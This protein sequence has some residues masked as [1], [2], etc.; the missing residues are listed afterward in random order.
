MEGVK[1]SLQ[2][3]FVLSRLLDAMSVEMI[4][5]KRFL[6]PGTGL[7]CFSCLVSSSQVLFRVDG[8]ILFSILED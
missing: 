5:E 7:R 8:V 4:N 3:C 2:G 6:L 1:L